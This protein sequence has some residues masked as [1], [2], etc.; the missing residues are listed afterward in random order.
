VLE[1]GLVADGTIAQDSA[2]VAGIWALREGVSVALKHAGA[3]P[4]P[5]RRRA[6]RWRPATRGRNAGPLVTSAV[7][8]LERAPRRAPGAEKGGGRQARRTS[9]T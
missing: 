2:Q 1:E 4:V 5:A 6:S 7:A 3:P 8:E 9:T